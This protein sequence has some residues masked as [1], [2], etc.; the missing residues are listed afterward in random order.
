MEK[1]LRKRV[2]QLLLF[3]PSFRLMSCELDASEIL[4]VK[5]S[6]GWRSGKLGGWKI[7]GG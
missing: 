4:F 6:F 3:V 5:A 7:V 1:P 2:K